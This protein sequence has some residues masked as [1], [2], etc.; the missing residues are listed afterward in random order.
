MEGVLP[1][2]KVEFEV[3]QPVFVQEVLHRLHGVGGARPPVLHVGEGKGWVPLD[4]QPDHLLAVIERGDRRVD[5]MRRPRC[6]KEDDP[7]EVEELPDLLGAPQMA[8][9]D[10]I[11][12]SS[13]QS[14]FHV[15]TCPFP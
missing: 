7:V 1:E 3:F 9:V 13:K 15:L 6:R 10:R 11:K 2:D 8:D 4:G 12:R 14:P 5:L